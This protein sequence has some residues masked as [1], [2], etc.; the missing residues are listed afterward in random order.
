VWPGAPF[1][2][3]STVTSGSRSPPPSTSTITLAIKGGSSAW[4]RFGRVGS[5]A[6]DGAFDGGED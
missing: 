1:S 5:A 6:S 2:T 3:F 4:R